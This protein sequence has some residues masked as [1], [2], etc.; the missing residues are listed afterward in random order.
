MPVAAPGAKSARIAG[1]SARNA[2]RR[3]LA[4]HP[5]PVAAVY[6]MLDGVELEEVL[7]GATW[8]EHLILLGSPFAAMVAAKGIVTYKLSTRGASPGDEG[9]GGS[10]SVAIDQQDLR[11]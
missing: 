4:C 8:D 5:T 1:S 11:R 3:P 2:S 7:P 10:R 9:V 6:T